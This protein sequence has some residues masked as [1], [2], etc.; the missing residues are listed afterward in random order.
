MADHTLSVTGRLACIAESLQ[1]LGRIP[2]ETLRV[3]DP[4]T[5][6]CLAMN[7]DAW[8]LGTEG[9]SLEFSAMCAAAGLRP[10]AAG[11]AATDEAPSS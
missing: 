10:V 4:E 11:A 8:G 5:Y 6:R 2:I 3:V 1:G 9:L 7:L